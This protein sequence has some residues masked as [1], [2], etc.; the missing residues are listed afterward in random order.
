VTANILLCIAALAEILAGFGINSVSLVVSLQALGL[1]V[2]LAAV[3]A[4]RLKA[5]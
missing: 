3:L 1:A 4:D 5:P 2:A